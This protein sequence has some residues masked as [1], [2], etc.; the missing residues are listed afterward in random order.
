MG[1]IVGPKEQPGRTAL[2]HSVAENRVQTRAASKCLAHTSERGGSLCWAALFIFLGG[3]FESLA[4]VTLL[5]T[6]A[7]KTSTAGSHFSAFRSNQRFCVQVTPN[8]V[9]SPTFN[10]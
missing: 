9:Q 5:T 2:G 4:I 6:P 1:R 3:A 8:F 7:G 10:M